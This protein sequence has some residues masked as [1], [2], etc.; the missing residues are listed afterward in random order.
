MLANLVHISSLNRMGREGGRPNI[1]LPIC[2][3][4]KFPFIDGLVF[5]LHNPGGV[6]HTV[7]FFC[8]RNKT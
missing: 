7:F 2:C 1:N 8:I 6:P 5:F 3:D 4:E